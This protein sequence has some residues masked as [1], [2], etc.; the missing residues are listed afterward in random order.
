[1]KIDLVLRAAQPRGPQTYGFAP[2]ADY[3]PWI[4]ITGGIAA[5]VVTLVFSRA[6]YVTSD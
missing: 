2:V 5:L 6:D 1:M 3:L 4:L